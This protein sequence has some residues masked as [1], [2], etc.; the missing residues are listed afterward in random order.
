MKSA[1]V[2]VLS[3]IELKNARWN[4]E[5]RS[6]YLQFDMAQTPHINWI[7]INHKWLFVTFAK[8][9]TIFTVE[10]CKQNKMDFLK[11][12]LAKRGVKKLE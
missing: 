7:F 5:I 11:K 4:I 12:L 10:M 2:G 8:Y 6:L 1:C 9:A 3:I